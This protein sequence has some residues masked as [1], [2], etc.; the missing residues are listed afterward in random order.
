MHPGK[1]SIVPAYRIILGWVWLGLLETHETNCLWDNL[2]EYMYR[3]RVVKG[4]S[5]QE[6]SCRGRVVRGPVLIQ[7]HDEILALGSC[8]TSLH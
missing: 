4:A 3:G 6:V 8:Y 7:F 5:C 1:G 2:S